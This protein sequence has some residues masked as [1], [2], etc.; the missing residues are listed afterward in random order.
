MEK[1]FLK[2]T[3]VQGKVDSEEHCYNATHI[4]GGNSPGKFSYLSKDIQ[5]S[6]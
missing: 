3:S 1:M 5:T 6:R 4:G 2:V